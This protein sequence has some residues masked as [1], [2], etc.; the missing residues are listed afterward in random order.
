MSDTEEEFV[1]SDDEVIDLTNS[2]GGGDDGVGDSDI[3]ILGGIC[4]CGA[5]GEP[6]T[7]RYGGPLVFCCESAACISDAANF[8]STSLPCSH[9]CIGVYGE[10]AR[11]PPCAEC[12]PLDRCTICLGPMAESPTVALL[13]SHLFHA[14]CLLTFTQTRTPPRI[15]FR[16]CADC[17]V[18]SAP[19]AGVDAHPALRDAVAELTAL[20]AKVESMAEK[21]IVT[22]GLWP[23]KSAGASVLAAVSAAAAPHAPADVVSSIAAMRLDFAMRKLS[24]Y[25][26]TRCMDPYFAGL[27]V[28]EEDA[29]AA[30]AHPVG[31]AATAGSGSAGGRG[32]PATIRM[33]SSGGGAGA[34]ERHTIG[35]GG[36]AGGVFGGASSS[37]SS[38]A[39]KRSRTDGQ[40]G[41]GAEPPKPLCPKC[42]PRYH[43]DTCTHKP[44]PDEIAM[45]CRYCCS[46][47]THACRSG[48]N[49]CEDV[50]LRPLLSAPHAHSKYT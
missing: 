25:S 15:E 35:A 29:G 20:R 41:A 17:P 24:Y 23:P 1:Y 30:D 13:C 50:L 34:G 3:E 36:S 11:H 49:H 42:R 43:S 8:C 40:A 39:A 9:R 31:S 47:A 2:P 46:R 33:D 21:R 5:P 19:I 4:R 14:D 7:A 10:G 48:L 12:S 38:S 45:K 32:L 6:R 37:P 27:K 26:C 18:C 22:E 44:E 28:C 16:T